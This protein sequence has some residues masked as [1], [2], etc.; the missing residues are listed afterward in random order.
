MVPGSS[1]RGSRVFLTAAQSEHG[2]SGVCL[3]L[4]CEEPAEVQRKRHAELPQR[5]TFTRPEVYSAVAPG[6]PH[7]PK[8]QMDVSSLWRK[9]PGHRHMHTLGHSWAFACYCW[10]LSHIRGILIRAAAADRGWTG[11]KRKNV[12]G[13]HLFAQYY[14]VHPKHFHSTRNNG[15]VA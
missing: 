12:M 4:S 13:L 14:L 1:S 2:G 11:R 10:I 7:T 6:A 5:S 15:H 9:K 8:T 3:F